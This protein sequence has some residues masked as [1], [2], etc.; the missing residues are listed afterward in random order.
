MPIR[1][2]LNNFLK[3]FE[4]KFQ[5]L[6]LI[7][8]SRSNLLHNYDLFSSLLPGYS[9]FPVL[10]ANAYG[11]GIA[12]ITEI[13]KERQPDYFIV[14][15]YFEAL[16]VWEISKQPVLLIGYVHPSN[17]KDLDFHNLALTVYDMETIK[18]LERLGRKVRIHL[19]IDTGMNRQGIE[20]KDIPHFIK[21]INKAQNL[22]LE[23]VLSHLADADSTDNSYTQKQL[24]YYRKAHK[25]VEEMS[26]EIRHSHLSASAGAIKTKDP[27]TN[28]VRIGMGLYGIN[29]YEPKDPFYKKLEDLKPVLTLK[30]TIIHTKEIKKG[31]AVS[32]NCTFKAK[33][34]TR[35]GLL[36]LGYY[37][38]IPRNLSNKGFVRWEKKYLPII[39][40]VC[41]N[42]TIVDLTDTAAKKFDKIT[43]VSPVA[44]D[45]NSIQSIANQ[46]ATIPDDIFV[47]LNENIRRAIS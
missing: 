44:S 30:S 4:R 47:H 7:E 9:I 22:E 15:G 27:T 18:E 33:R 16:R 17:L 29:P 11:H 14:D 31:D 35:I 21:E 3:R 24:E 25:I 36:P 43:V 37:E 5:T 34:K 46:S 20:N 45:K 10:K 41:M 12:Q 8:I 38:G 42:L 6:N 28:S 39:G 23:G 26:G 1:S 2:K 32:Y 40:R 13:L 19:K